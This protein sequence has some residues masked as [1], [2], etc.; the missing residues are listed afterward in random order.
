MKTLSI[1]LI[2]LLP[3]CFLYGQE[4]QPTPELPQARVTAIQV[5]PDGG[6]LF[7]VQLRATSSAPLA[8][9]RPPA[10][11]PNG[12]AR[13]EGDDDPRPFSL[14]ASTLTDLDTEQVLRPLQLLP[15]KPFVGP[16]ET[17]STLAPGGWTQMGV[18]FP[19]LPPPRRNEQTG[20]AEPYRLMFRIPEL[21]IETPLTLDPETKE[22]VP[23]R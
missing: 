19:P 9:S 14:A 2:W 20:V 8:L 12:Q 22:L 15:R 17:T 1:S 6:L 3:L 13:V 23:S 16:M 21:Q 5:L 4:A 11:I 18:A 10:P 7:A